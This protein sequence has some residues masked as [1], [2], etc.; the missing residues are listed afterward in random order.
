ME[1]K[2]R[3]EKARALSWLIPQKLNAKMKTPSLTPIPFMLTGMLIS[4]A[5]TE[6]STANSGKE[7]F[8]SRDKQKK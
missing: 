4:T 1:E 8:I 6:Y 2:E 7:I 3:N 5:Q